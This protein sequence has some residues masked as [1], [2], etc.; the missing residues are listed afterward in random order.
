MRLFGALV[1]HLRNRGAVDRAELAELLQGMAERSSHSALMLL[2]AAETLRMI[3]SLGP[4]LTATHEG[5]ED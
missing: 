4:V 2:P 5:P 1:A 3:E